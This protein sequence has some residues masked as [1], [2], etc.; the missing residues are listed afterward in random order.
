MFCHPF[1]FVAPIVRPSYFL[2]VE[3]WSAETVIRIPPKRVEGWALPDM[4]G[5]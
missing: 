4:P 1:T 5:L 3:T 2:Q